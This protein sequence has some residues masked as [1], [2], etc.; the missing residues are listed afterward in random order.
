[1]EPVSSKSRMQPA[2]SSPMLNASILEII[3]SYVGP[4][5]WLYLRTLSKSCKESYLNVEQREIS[6]WDFDNDDYVTVQCTPR[7]TLTSAAFLSLA[8]FQLAVEHGMPLPSRNST[9]QQRLAGENASI[10]TLQAAHKLGLQFTDALVQGA[11]EVGSVAELNWLHEEHG[12]KFDAETM[13][14]ATRLRVCKFLRTCG[15][16]M[17]ERTCC[18]SSICRGN[19]ELLNWL[20]EQGCHWEHRSYFELA[21]ANER[22]DMMAYLLQIESTPELL[23]A[24]L[25]DA[26]GYGLLEGA[27]WLRQRGAEWPAVLLINNGR[28]AWEPEAVASARAERCTSEAPE[29]R[30]YAHSSDDSIDG[31][32]PYGIAPEDLDFHPEAELAAVEAQFSG[33]SHPTVISYRVVQREQNT[34]L[35]W[36]YHR[37]RVHRTNYRQH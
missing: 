19:V 21:A 31:D 35:F 26:G 36:R 37:H 3:F 6:F 2:S 29:P 20:R 7:L 34:A 16:P 5:H 25:N 15:C 12:C 33:E 13:Y 11:A 24:M 28:D 32:A 30:E 9:R 14:A 4:G 27:Q 23:T 1:M 8:C 18:R 10:D 22:I 17:D